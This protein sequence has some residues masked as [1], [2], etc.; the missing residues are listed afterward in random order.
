M[1]GLLLSGISLKTS[2]YFGRERMQVLNGRFFMR[3]GGWFLAVL[4]VLLLAGGCG[5]LNSREGDRKAAFDNFVKYLRY[6][7]YPAAGSYFSP[8]LREAFLDQMEEVKGLNVTDVRLVRVDV[9][10]DG[11]RVDTRLEV[12]YYLLP[13]V[14][15]KTLRVDQVWRH[16]EDPLEGELFFITTPF[17]KFS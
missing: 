2:V 6:Q 17:P 10:E 15:V 3:R 1:D 8:E 16:R 13:S 9:K 12:D 14:T 11:E 7:L 4:M 5:L